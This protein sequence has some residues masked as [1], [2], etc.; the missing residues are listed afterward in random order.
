M[1]NEYFYFDVGNRRRTRYNLTEK[2]IEKQ[3]LGEFGPVWLPTER[4]PTP[5]DI[6]QRFGTSDYREWSKWGKLQQFKK[7]KNSWTTKL[8][9]IFT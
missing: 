3:F 6:L 1:A 9:N 5:D 8:I 4:N 2:H 7:R